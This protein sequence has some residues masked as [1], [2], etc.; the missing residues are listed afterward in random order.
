M[1]D[2]IPARSKE[3]D[4]G[5]ELD[6]PAEHPARGIQ[7]RW[8][9]DNEKKKIEDKLRLLEQN[10]VRKVANDFTYYT[11]SGLQKSLYDIKAD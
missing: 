1:L 9:K 11:T 4:K 2:G 10:Q 3:S 5:L 8:H 6:I 7:L